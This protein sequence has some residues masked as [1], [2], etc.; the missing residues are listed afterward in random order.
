MAS[1]GLNIKN[2]EKPSGN[3]CTPNSNVK[4]Y[5]FN[6]ISMNPDG[7]QGSGVENL[8]LLKGRDP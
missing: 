5:F 1:K 4:N 7:V 2:F 6:N 8:A 3:L